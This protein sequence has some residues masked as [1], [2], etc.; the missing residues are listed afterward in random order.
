MF[1]CEGVEICI[2]RID[3]RGV[4]YW[5][6]GYLAVWDGIDS[7]N[8]GF[9]ETRQ[10]AVSALIAKLTEDNK[11]LLARLGRYPSRSGFNHA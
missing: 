9:G 6:V 8:E 1:H 10:L 4:D 2:T 3:Y 7:Y 5:M 11:A